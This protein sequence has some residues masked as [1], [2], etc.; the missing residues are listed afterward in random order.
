MFLSGVLLIQV[1]LVRILV[2]PFCN[3]FK[4]VKTYFT[5]LWFGSATAPKRVLLTTLCKPLAVVKF[6]FAFFFGGSST[7]SKTFVVTGAAIST[8][9][10]V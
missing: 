4:L 10:S 2:K 8:V 9:E 5:F 3:R 7:A 1:I 6:S